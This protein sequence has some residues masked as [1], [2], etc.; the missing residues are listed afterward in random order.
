MQR[1][2]R[3]VV[4]LQ[5]YSMLYIAQLDLSTRG[6]VLLSRSTKQLVAVVRGPGVADQEVGTIRTF[7]G[8]DQSCRA[9]LFILV[10]RQ[11]KQVEG[12]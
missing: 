3:I 10:T 4:F 11:E 1:L 2:W 9:S 7:V 8:P 5:Y 6:I 12:T